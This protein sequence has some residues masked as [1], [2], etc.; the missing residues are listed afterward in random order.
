[1]LI[2]TN[3]TYPKMA[4]V[5]QHFDTS[6]IEDVPGAIRAEMARLGVASRVRPGMHIAVTAGSRGITGIPVILA[7][8]V[9]ELKRLG[10]VPFLVPCMGSH[11]GATAEGQVSVLHSLGVTEETAGCPIY[12]SMDTVQIGQTSGGIPVFMDKIAAG[13]D[14]IVVVNRIKAHTD[15]MGAIG[16]GWLKMLTIGLGKHRGALTAHRNILQLTHPVV[17]LSVAREVIRKAPLLFGLGVVEN[18]Y[19]QTAEVVAAWPQDFEETEKA[20]L[21]R[22]RARMARLP[23]RQMDILIVDELGKEISGAG[24]DPNVTGRGIAHDG[25]DSLLPDIT[26]I[27][28]R[29]LSEKT[30]GNAVGVG[31]ADFVTQRLVDKLDRHSTYIN[32]LTSGG[33][34]GA[35]IPMTSPTDRE[36]VEWAF[37]TIGPVESTEARVVHI[38][39]TLHL[40]RFYASEALRPEVEADPQLEI[41]EKWA[42]MAFDESGVLLP[43]RVS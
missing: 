8:V 16:S 37:L 14:G 38:Q 18:A 21:V 15:F 34:G 7:T 22:A 35:S 11:G 33:P 9:G 25:P 23:F 12:S 32:C 39:N 31:M 5:A 43:G 13:A 1:M 20:M 4:L 28:V 19:D 40:E 42:P 26:R 27:V 24:M 36:A 10:A 2:P 41:L 29:D 17:I 30:H 3:I 6:H